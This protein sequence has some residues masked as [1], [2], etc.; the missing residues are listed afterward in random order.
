MSQ[1]DQ[2]GVVSKALDQAK[3]FQLNFNPT[4]NSVLSLV[5]GPFTDRVIEIWGKDRVH[6]Y[7]GAPDA[8]RHVWN[9]W[10][11]AQPS[12]DD[13]YTVL[14]RAK[15]RQIIQNGYG[16]CPAG[17][18]STLGRLGPAS[19][20]VKFYLSL[21]KVIAS[22][23]PLAQ[24]LFHQKEIPSELVFVLSQLED[25]DLSRRAVS[26]LIGKS[27]KPRLFRAVIWLIRRLVA[28]SGDPGVEDATLNS[29]NPI[30]A[31]QKLAAQL[32]FPPPP[33]GQLGSLGPVESPAILASL[34]K[35]FRN[36]LSDRN[37][38]IDAA[39]SVQ[40]GR[41][42]YYH[43]TGEHPALLM[44]ARVGGL[45]WSLHEAAGPNNTPLHPDT[46]MEI[47]NALCS[48]QDIWPIDLHYSSAVMFD[49][50]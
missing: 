14:S 21:F 23:G 20:T 17:M 18:V 31:A 29:K 50:Y 25:D 7:L 49:D 37:R 16:L 35:S 24:W 33:W 22:G 40:S 9:S 39:I 15:S 45:G 4:H 46:E 6:E 12:A 11:A 32:P 30:L 42:Y 48:I 36:C 19:R 26:K 13:A 34:G 5:A 28:L 3:L 1:Q 27:A 10:L 41:R 8:R 47:Q 2:T 43:W 44:F 38:W